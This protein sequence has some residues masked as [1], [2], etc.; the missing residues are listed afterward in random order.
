MTQGSQ[1][2]AAES[3]R[4]RARRGALTQGAIIDLDA[5]RNDPPITSRFPS[6]NASA[7]SH[8]CGYAQRRARPAQRGPMSGLIDTELS[9]AQKLL[10]EVVLE[11]QVSRTPSVK[12]QYSLIQ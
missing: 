5:D 12:H 4:A 1:T 9:G 11:L 7:H 10:S 3:G 6:P 2:R 8:A